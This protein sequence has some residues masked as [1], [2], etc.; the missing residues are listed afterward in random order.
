MADNGCNK[1]IP[2]V[3]KYRPSKLNDIVLDPLNKAI[4]DN[5][6]ESK[7]IKVNLEDQLMV[8][9]GSL[10]Y[11]FT[12][13]SDKKDLPDFAIG[14]LLIPHDLSPVFRHNTEID[15]EKYSCIFVQF[16]LVFNLIG[17]QVSGFEI[18]AKLSAF[19]VCKD[20]NKISGSIKLNGPED[21]QYLSNIILVRE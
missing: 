14:S 9:Q 11:S 12:I 6:I 1:T 17:G 5:I 15:G 8:Q 2:W 20:G 18:N 13:Y 10:G 4:I 19:F 16:N 7:I 3:E 21:S